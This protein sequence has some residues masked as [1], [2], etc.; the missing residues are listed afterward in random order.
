MQQSVVEVLAD[1]A[2]HTLNGMAG[3]PSDRGHAPM[4]AYPKA[5]AAATDATRWLS[6][7]SGLRPLEHAGLRN[8]LAGAEALGPPV[9]L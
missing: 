6:G 4:P 1:G 8:I 5:P 7:S 9:I 2:G 3:A